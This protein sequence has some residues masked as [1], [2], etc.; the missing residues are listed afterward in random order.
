MIFELAE[1]SRPHIPNPAFATYAARYDDIYANFME[2]VQQSGIEIDPQ[3][4]RPEAAVL[5]EKLREKGAHVRNADKSIYI[6]HISP[7]CEACQTGVGSA[8]YFVSLKCHRSCYYCF[9][10]NQDQYEYHSQ[11]QRDVSAEL[12]QVSRRGLKFKHLALT[13]GEPLLFKQ[14]TYDFFQTAERLY[15]DAYTRLYTCGDYADEAALHALKES[16][17]D[18]IRFSIRMHDLEN[19]QRFVF[20]RIQQAQSLIPYVMVEMPVL[21]G[22]KAIMQDVLRELDRIGIFSINLLEFCYPFINADAFNQRGFRVKN[23]PFQILY[24]YWYA[25]GL[26][27]SGSELLCLELVEFALDEGLSMGVHYC[28]LENKHTGQVYQQNIRQSLAKTAYFSERDYFIKTAKVFGDDISPVLQFFKRT[29]YDHY[30]LN[31]ELGYLEFHPRKIH[32]LRHMQIAIGISYNIFEKRG[33]ETVLRELKIALTTPQL[34]DFE[35]DL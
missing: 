32:S 6:N 28:S 35:R 5:L 12:E 18:E 4:H 16:G 22:S 25:G 11:N 17:L 14:E 29:H 13:G 15:P 30:Q 21:P 33:L 27:I 3:D 1:H 20:E 19:G 23:P 31:D 34:F 10:P 24:N 7:A 2:Q 9:N 26:P 8:T